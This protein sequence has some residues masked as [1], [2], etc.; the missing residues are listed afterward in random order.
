MKVFMSP[1][2][3]LMPELQKT[4]YSGM[5]SEGTKVKEF[6]DKLQANIGCTSRPLS[7]NSG[8]SALH[9]A[10]R[11]A[12]VKDK[13]VLTTPMT[14][15]ATNMPIL[16]EGGKIVWCDIDP[17]TGNISVESVKKNLQKYG[18]Q[19]AAISFVD[20]AGYPAD[21]HGLI[22]LRNKYHVPLIEDAAQSFGASVFIGDIQYPVWVEYKVGSIPEVDYCTFSF[23]AIKHLTTVDGGALVCNDPKKWEIAKRL[24]WYGINRESVKD[25][26]RWHYDIIEAGDKWHMNNVNA[27]IGICQLNYVENIV[28]KHRQN[29]KFFDNELKSVPGLQQMSLISGIN[30]SYWIYMIR[31][32]NRE[33]FAKMMTSNGIDVNVAHIRNDGYTC[34][35]DIDKVLNVGEDLAGL[36][37]FND[38]YISIPSGW[39]L[40]EDDKSYIVK[41]IKNGW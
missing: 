1:P 10:Y 24:K 15:T 29:G 26:T 16:H 3:E 21:I 30:P 41:C 36:T 12:N 2:E 34:F 32:E 23:Q 27:T 37:E 33:N 5:V 19:V 7:V 40:T 4:L 35:R 8:T 13:I 22:Y 11:C 18:D 25:K 28:Y 6:E 17:D 20:F 39:W 9:L 31:V 38:Q 14:C